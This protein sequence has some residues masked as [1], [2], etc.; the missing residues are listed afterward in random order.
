[1]IRRF[2]HRVALFLLILFASTQVKGQDYPWSL[3]YITNMYTINPAYVG[4]WDRAGLGISNRV[5]WVGIN[6]AALYQQL[7]YNT[8]IKDQKSGFGLN[9]QKLNI[10]YEKRL[11]LTADYS[12]QIRLDM[13]YYMRFGFRA[14][15]LNLDNNLNDY[16]L[17]PDH[18]T[19]PEFTTNVRLRYMTLFGVGAVLYNEDYYISFSIPQMIRNSFNVNKDLYSSMPKITTMYFSSGYAFRIAGSLILRPNLLLI[20]T[21]GKPIYFDAA[22]L[23]YF[24]G[25]LQLGLHLRTNG[26]MCL[27]G[28][29]T[30]RNNLRIGYAAEYFVLQD[31]SKYQLGTY[32]FFVG[33]DFNLYRRKNIRTNYF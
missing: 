17:Y 1:M 23:L 21:I 2:I 27:S 33:Y 6:G 13:H 31:I 14:G 30:F 9:L 29:Y 11:S 22:S 19:D 8:P 28:Q 32:E 20:E 10:G 5:N 25:N 24:P 4:I 12:Y 16:H 3:Q 7:S 15:I 18:I 26:S